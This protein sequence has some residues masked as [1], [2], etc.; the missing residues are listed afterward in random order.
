MFLRKK[1]PMRVG[2][3]LKTVLNT[4]WNVSVGGEELDN[5]VDIDILQNIV[6]KCTTAQRQIATVVELSKRYPFLSVN[7][8]AVFRA[9]PS[10]VPPLFC[11]VVHPAKGL[12]EVVV[13][14]ERYAEVVGKWELTIEGVNEYLEWIKKQAEAKLKVL[15]QPMKEV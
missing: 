3:Y 1:K 2:D 5:V 15:L 10:V 4:M 9:L 13:E 7:I 11:L 14:R 6:E 8:G 12:V